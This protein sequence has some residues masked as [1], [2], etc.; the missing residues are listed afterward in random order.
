[1]SE[2]N[3]MYC[4]EFTNGTQ[5]SCEVF[6]E[7]PED[8]PRICRECQHGFS[9]HPE[10]LRAMEDTRRKYT[11]SVDQA[12]PQL[13]SASGPSGRQRVLAMFNGR[14]EL[15][16]AEHRSDGFNICKRNP[17]MEEA[18]EE[19]LKGYRT[20]PAGGKGKTRVR[21][22]NQSQYE[23]HLLTSFSGSCHLFLLSRCALQVSP[24]GLLEE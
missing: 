10:G 22:K 24:P 1:M 3:T 18:K 20:Q 6:S 17:T 15:G 12:R 14:A 23:S 19:I 4:R 11:G 7:P 5:C 9:K 8:A 2:P 13:P 21:N 16:A